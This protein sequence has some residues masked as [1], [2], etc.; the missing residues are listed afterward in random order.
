[1]KALREAKKG[2]D[3]VA[4]PPKTTKD[5]IKYEVHISG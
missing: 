2:T 4:K 3:K 1:M 5:Y